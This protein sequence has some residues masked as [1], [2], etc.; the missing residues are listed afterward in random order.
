[1]SKKR[2]INKIKSKLEL[3]KNN[4]KK[5]GITDSKIFLFGSWAKG[6]QT[7][8]SDIDICII[9]NKFVDN[10]RF[11]DNVKMKLYANNID[12][13]IEP[14]VFNYKDFENKY[15]TLVTEIKKYGILI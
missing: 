13:N 12:D 11:D 9:S 7:E 15:D 2:N 3:F 14:V 4:L 5:E 8:S 6:K 10:T 1:M